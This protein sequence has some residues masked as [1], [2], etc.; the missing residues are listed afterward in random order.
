[1]D[2]ALGHKIWKVAYALPYDT[3]E[4]RADSGVLLVSHLVGCLVARETDCDVLLMLLSRFQIDTGGLDYDELESIGRLLRA[5]PSRAREFV[6]A[7]H[8]NAPML[9]EALDTAVFE[10]E[11]NEESTADLAE[12]CGRAFTALLDL[13]VEL[14]ADA[15][16]IVGAL[17]ALYPECAVLREAFGRVVDALTDDDLENF[18][19]ANDA[20]AALVADEQA[21]RAHASQLRRVFMEHQ[22]AG[23]PRAAPARK[24][25][26]TG[27]ADGAAAGAGDAEPDAGSTAE[28]AVVLRDPRFREHRDASGAAVDRRMY[29][30]NAGSVTRLLGGRRRRRAGEPS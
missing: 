13:D 10:D 15:P 26:R 3:P 24:R 22:V 16:T 18:A 30:F 28:L 4:E 23:T 21:Y 11:E 9:Y 17:A 19:Q 14:T 12:Q 6:D 7:M 1:M 8:G 27:E 2:E 25:G 20:H 29:N 5:N